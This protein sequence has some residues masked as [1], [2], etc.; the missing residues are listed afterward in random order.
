MKTTD[1]LVRE[2]VDREAIRELPMRYCD[3][4]YRSDLDGLVNLFT[5]GASFIVRDPENEVVT[6]G[7]T[8]LKKMYEQLMS[9]VWPRPFVHSHVIAFRTQ[10]SATGRC[11][12]ELRSAKVDMEQTGSGCYEDEYVKVG[13]QWKFASRRLIEVDLA[14]SLRP[15]MV[16]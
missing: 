11:Y 7:R 10:T 9:E 12:V 13:D 15:F 2:L 1:E 6:R 3:C 14:T 4:L 5:E 16:N 8:D